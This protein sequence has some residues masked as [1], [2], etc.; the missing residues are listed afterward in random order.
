[1]GEQDVIGPGSI[2]IALGE[3]WLHAIMSILIYLV[4]GS[5]SSQGCYM[6]RP[7][8]MNFG[9]PGDVPIK[10][11]R[12][13][14]AVSQRRLCLVLKVVLI[15]STGTFYVFRDFSFEIFQ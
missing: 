5:V 3:N 14:D 15:Q 2:S 4:R 7:R 6:M 10:S 8:V 11:W 13:G 12:K 9:R 1:V